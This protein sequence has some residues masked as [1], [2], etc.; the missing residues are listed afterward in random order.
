MGFRGRS[1]RPVILKTL[2]GSFFLVRYVQLL[3]VNDFTNLRKLNRFPRV[4]NKTILQTFWI[5]CFINQIYP[6]NFNILLKPE[7]K[8]FTE[9]H[10]TIRDFGIKYREMQNASYSNKFLKI[11]DGKK[12]QS[13]H[14]SHKKFV[15]FQ[16]FCFV[17]T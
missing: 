14:L 1:I 5:I 3:L 11:L 15:L 7:I 6:C 8:R 10:V 4:C 2:G 16:R 9:Y 17:K 13:I 12:P